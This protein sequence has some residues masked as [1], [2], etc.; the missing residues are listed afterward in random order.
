MADIALPIATSPL[1]ALL[2]GMPTDPA[3]TI[4]TPQAS[5]PFVA[6][7]AA[8]TAMPAPTAPTAPF[9][10]TVPAA[11]NEP[12]T[13]TIP[14][15]PVGPITVSIETPVN[16]MAQSTRATR[17]PTA[18][19]KTIPIAPRSFPTVESLPLD[20]EAALPVATEDKSADR[21]K[22][23]DDKGKDPLAD[24][25]ASGAN[26]VL[27]LVPT[28]VA[29]IQAP[30]PADTPV[31]I[32]APFRASA[33]PKA[34]AVVPSGPP[35]AV[36][37]STT[38]QA[39]VL[40]ESQ[41]A[42]SID[43]PE[44]AHSDPSPLPSPRADGDRRDP[45]SQPSAPSSPPVVATSLPP[46][47][48]KAVVAA[49]QQPDSAKPVLADTVTAG[50][51][52]AT[53]P[54]VS[55]KQVKETPPAAVQT[56]QETPQQPVAP[57]AP[58]RRRS[59]EIANVRRPSDNRKRV[60]TIDPVGITQRAA[61]TSHV[62]AAPHNAATVA[63]KGD[64]VVQQTLTIGR[65][66][67]WLDR[68]ARDIAGAS[69]GGDL[70]FKLNPQ[71]LGSL[72]VAISQSEDGASIRLTADTDTT[73]N[74][75]LDA[76]PKLIAEARAQGLKVGE[77]HVELSQ[78]QSQSQ[79]QSQ[80][81]NANQDMSRWAQGS[82]SQSGNSQTGQ[83]RQSSPSHQPFVSNLARKAEVESESPGGD[84]DALYA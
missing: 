17:L 84:S 1:A 27:A 3:A 46:E 30:P 5:H 82:A 78:S 55:T 9:P 81:Q 53:P 51:A 4:A 40:V 12:T 64:A 60:E 48:A 61:E 14:T 34:A 76:Q 54:A 39:P 25:I 58:V 83:N 75:L 33:F 77:T 2:A 73:R 19:I 59:D 69:N 22:T 6:L 36:P 24:A 35:V 44:I 21:D 47:V 15:T 37:K 23:I 10:S 42:K 16:A 74:L 18:P 38:T 52:I 49:L 50:D 57:R 8:V 7:L 41:P 29:P 28:I 20:P 11:P 71:N 79:N 63:A 56:Q 67:A 26:A 66:G 72:A 13:P 31:Q 45:Q 80:H 32:D 68:L 43:A 70:H 65:D 62:S